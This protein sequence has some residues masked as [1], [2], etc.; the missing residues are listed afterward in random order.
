M[1]ITFVNFGSNLGY[2]TVVGLSKAF[3]SEVSKYVGYGV[4]FS[5]IVPVI[6]SIILPLAGIGYSYFVIVFFIGNFY[7]ISLIY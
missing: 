5:S 6:V 1:A 4:A 2:I 3:P 7:Q